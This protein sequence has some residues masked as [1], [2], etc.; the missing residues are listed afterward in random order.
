MNVVVIR[1]KMI[2]AINASE[3]P[4]TLV[5]IST[6]ILTIYQMWKEAFTLDLLPYAKNKNKLNGYLL[7]FIY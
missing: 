6:S 5:D 1:K 3:I 2:L 4:L 7:T